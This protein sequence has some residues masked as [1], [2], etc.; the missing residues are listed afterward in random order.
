MNGHRWNLAFCNEHEA[1]RRW[2][3]RF[4]LQL[5]CSEAPTSSKNN[6]IWGY[7]GVDEVLKKEDCNRIHIN[8][9]SLKINVNINFGIR[10]ARLENLDDDKAWKISS[11]G[12]FIYTRKVSLVFHT[13]IWIMISEGNV[14]CSKNSR[15]YQFQLTFIII[16]K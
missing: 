1:R 8:S 16:H 4:V 12:I 11:K 13:Y 5:G 9:R 10:A 2:I 7:R 6:V 3:R 14:N 15:T